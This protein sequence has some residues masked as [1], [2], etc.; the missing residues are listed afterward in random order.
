MLRTFIA[1]A[2]AVVDT[3]VHAPLIVGASYVSPDATEV[4]C[5][6]WARVI[7]KGLGV[8]LSVE[9]REHLDPAQPYVY[10]CNHLS[11][12][13][14]PSCYL[15]LPGHLR[16][17]AKKSLFQIPV[18]GWALHRSGQIPIDRSDAQS[19]QTKLN[20]NVEAI[21]TRI[22]VLLF[23]EGTRSDDGTLQPFKK[24]AAVLAIQAQVPI[25]PMAIA[26]SREIL[27]KGFNAI[28]GGTVRIRI[29][30]PIPTRGMSLEERGALTE[31]VR[32]EVARLQVG[33]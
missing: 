22:S 31:R 16:L 28:H 33:L 13:D 2:T 12:V 24:G 15:A 5:R 18:F 21:K 25:V 23:P 3:A 10:A 20:A 32:A 17:A 19:A 27:P 4:V 8:T 11:H 26:G 9:G 14:P 7:L 30:T 6:S 1:A 29:G